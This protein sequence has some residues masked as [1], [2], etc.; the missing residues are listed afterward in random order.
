M[1][2]KRLTIIEFIEAYEDGLLL[3]WEIYEIV[4]NFMCAISAY[5]K[6]LQS[7]IDIQKEKISCLKV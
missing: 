2:V 7:C 6:H 4:L 1:K 5:K 3:D